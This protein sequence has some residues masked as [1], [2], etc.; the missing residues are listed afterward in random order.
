LEYV[1]G[2]GGAAAGAKTA[3]WICEYPYHTMRLVGPSAECEDCPVWQELQ[4]NRHVLD[5]GGD[6]PNDPVE[7]LPITV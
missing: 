2:P 1:A 3:V 6:D 4:R 5:A 7:H